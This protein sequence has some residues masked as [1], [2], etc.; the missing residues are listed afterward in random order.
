M[1]PTIVYVVASEPER[2]AD[3]VGAAAEALLPESVREEDERRA[4]GLLVARHERA[5]DGRHA[6]E[7]RQAVPA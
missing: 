4:S 5:A 1:T 3:D 7:H 6:A 2:L